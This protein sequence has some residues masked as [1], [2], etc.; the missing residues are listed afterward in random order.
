MSRLDLPL[1]TPGTTPR[2]PSASYYYGIRELVIYKPYPSCPLSGMAEERYLDWLRK[3]EPE[4]AFDPERLHTQEDW[5]KA[6]EIVF[7]EPMSLTTAGV[8]G[9]RNSRF[10]TSSASKTASTWI[11]RGGGCAAAVFDGCFQLWPIFGYDGQPLI[12]VRPASVV[13]CLRLVRRRPRSTRFSVT[14]L[15]RRSCAAVS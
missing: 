13:A 9:G 10:L 3:Q 14:M 7:Y 11:T 4:I 15:L 8:Q 12:T 1:A 2:Y 6:G 5:I